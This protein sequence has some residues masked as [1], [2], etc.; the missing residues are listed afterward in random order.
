MTP[1]NNVAGAYIVYIIKGRRKKKKRHI[2]VA[3]KEL[4]QREEQSQGLE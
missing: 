1:V 4:L 3:M 2:Y